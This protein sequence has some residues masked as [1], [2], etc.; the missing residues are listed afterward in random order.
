LCICFDISINLSSVKFNYSLNSSF[1]FEIFS[2]QCQSTIISVGSHLDMKRQ[3]DGDKLS[4][5]CVMRKTIE[6]N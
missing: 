2:N 4:V 1:L 6:D 3:Y 5:S